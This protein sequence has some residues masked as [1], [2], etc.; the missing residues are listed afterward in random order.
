MLFPRD[1]SGFGMISRGEVE[2]TEE[3]GVV[4][5]EANI[6]VTPWPLGIWTMVWLIY[7][8]AAAPAFIHSV[9]GICAVAAMG[10]FNPYYGAKRQFEKYFE[11]LIDGLRFGTT[12]G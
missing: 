6:R 9:F 8:G 5:V 4:T 11:R 10:L 12:A 2:V 3:H 7:M 1:D